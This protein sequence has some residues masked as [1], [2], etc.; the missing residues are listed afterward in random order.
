MY[1]QRMEKL[2]ETV[3]SDLIGQQS[4]EKHRAIRRGGTMDKEQKGI[5]LG[6]LVPISRARGLVSRRQIK[7]GRRLERVVSFFHFTLALTASG[8]FGAQTNVFWN[9]S[10]CG[11]AGF[12]AV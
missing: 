8:D 12:P 1:L 7:D 2:I 9:V 3:S 6:F 4:S 5:S 10:R 11:E